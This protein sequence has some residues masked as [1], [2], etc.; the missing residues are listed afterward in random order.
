MTRYLVVF[1][2]VLP[3]LF[4]VF[5]TTTWAFTTTTTS[6]VSVVA[7]TGSTSTT[8]ILGAGGFEWE[9]P[10]DEQ[11]DQG[12]DNP[13]K[14]PDLLK[15]MKKE[16]DDE[17]GESKVIDPARLLGPRLQGSNL[18]LVGMMG[19]GKSS[20][21][22][23]LARR[24]GSYKFLDTDEII[25]KATKLSISEI[26]E[27]EGEEGFR[28]VESQVLDTVQS[29]VRCVISTGGG[30]VCKPKNWGKLQTGIVVWLDVAPEIILKRI[31]GNEDRP[32]LKT[33]DPL[34]TLK[35]LLEER[36]SKYSQA[37]FRV[38]ITEDMD[39]DMVASRI[40]LDMHNYIDDN[41]PAWKLA[42]QKAQEEGLDWVQ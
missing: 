37:D 39:E 9:D 4:H 25:E 16:G 6:S 36:E 5:G 3:V 1:A 27:S 10:T 13:F 35:D 34:Q 31:E 14:N 33:E 30:L 22:D 19:S 20:V 42:K 2:Q 21:G 17:D 28:D 24:M 32:L 41:P 12:V 15:A 29:Y 8:T 7:R 40:V 18:Y 38:E 23:K 11:F 26:F